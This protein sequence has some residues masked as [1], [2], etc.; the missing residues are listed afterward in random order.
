MNQWKKGYRELKTKQKT[1][2]TQR[3]FKPKQTNKQ[4]NPFRKGTCRKS[5]KPF[6]DQT[7]E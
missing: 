2:I 3:K 4:N 5:G 7:C 6:K 1:L